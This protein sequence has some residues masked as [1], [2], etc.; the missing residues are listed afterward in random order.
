LIDSVEVGDQDD[1]PENSI[2]HCRSPK[3][4]FACLF[5]V[6]N[7]GRHQIVPD[8]AVCIAEGTA[9]RAARFVSVR[10]QT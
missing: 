6:L 2:F 10:R 8:A 3:R 5:C 1:Q 9:Q 4:D 7:T